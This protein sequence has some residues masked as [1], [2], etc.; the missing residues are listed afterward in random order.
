MRKEFREFA[1]R[2]NAIDMAVGVVLGASFGGIVASLVNDILMPPLGLLAGRVDFSNL[3]LVLKEGTVPGPYA[4]VASAR[5]AGAVTVNYG[6]FVNTVIGFLIV[7]F[8]IFLVVRSFN[9]LAREEKTPPAEP[10]T[11][12]CRYCRSVIPAEAVRC[13]HCTSDLAAV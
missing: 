8:A 4:T 7:A 1:M 11:K 5:E 13:A 10:A 3:Y 9:R 6:L 2:G 12:E